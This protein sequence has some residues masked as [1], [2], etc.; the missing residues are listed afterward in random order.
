VGWEDASSHSSKDFLTSVK[1]ASAT[2]FLVPGLD[3]LAIS[4]ATFTASGGKW[5]ALSVW[6]SNPF[7][8][9]AG[10][11]VVASLFYNELCPVWIFYP[12]Q[13]ETTP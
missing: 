13:Y 12:T 4:F 3:I 1:I 7:N 6:M 10:Q 9:P 11:R 5:A 2:V 8:E